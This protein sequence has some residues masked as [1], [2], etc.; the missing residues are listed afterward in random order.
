VKSAPLGS[1]RPVAGK[2]SLSRK[3]LDA[4]EALSLSAVT[5]AVAE[6]SETSN[7]GQS[8][9][10][11]LLIPQPPEIR[12]KVLEFLEVKDLLALRR[13]NHALHE[14][15]HE[16]EAGLCATYRRTRPRTIPSISPVHGHARDLIF[17]IDLK[18]QDGRMWHL[19]HVLVDYF[20][21]Q[22]N[23]E[24]VTD[25]LR[26]H[27]SRDKKRLSFC[28]VLFRAMFMLDNFLE[29]LC[30]VMNDADEAFK[31]WDDDTYLA[32]VVSH[33]DPLHLPILPLLKL[34]VAR[35]HRTYPRTI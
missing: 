16:H 29:S 20:Y 9:V 34:R 30:V 8:D 14:L 15:V 33:H 24:G 25:K 27:A 6:L 3:Y 18:Q 26:D 7:G 13:V 22:S 4:M 31:D 17:Y 5:D 10:L 1:H 12:A 32:A 21:P 19:A 23:E 28:R 11:R 35:V 2:S